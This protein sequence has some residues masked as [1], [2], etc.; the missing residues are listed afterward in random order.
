MLKTAYGEM[1]RRLVSMVFALML[2]FVATLVYEIS[3]AS[4]QSL[5]PNY[6]HV[7]H[8]MV[9][10]YIILGNTFTNTRRLSWLSA[11]GTFATISLCTALIA[12]YILEINRNWTETP[13]E[14]PPGG[15][16]GGGHGGGRGGEVGLI[17]WHLLRHTE[18]WRGPVALASGFGVFA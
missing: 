17:P 4:M 11:A 6:D 5:I 16:G 9:I 1:G 8:L 3:V 12:S 14:G 18:L 15:V 10:I 13:N 7:P 2:L